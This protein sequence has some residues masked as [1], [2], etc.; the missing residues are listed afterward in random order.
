ML[1]NLATKQ[2]GL[3]I[4]ATSCHIP[5]S[6][7]ML[8]SCHVLFHS[9]WGEGWGGHD[10][11]NFVEYMKG[12]GTC[13]IIHAFCSVKWADI[14]TWL[15]CCVKC[16]ILGHLGE[17]HVWCKVDRMLLMQGHHNVEECH[18]HTWSPFF[19]SSKLWSI[20]CSGLER[21]VHINLVAC[22][23]I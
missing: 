1:D 18:L 22:R 10:Y 17:S 15:Q 6:T 5:L 3:R 14:A 20:H 21:P 19:F 2:K 4:V 8:K 7:W 12:G 9:L 11:V 16:S 23:A 13:G